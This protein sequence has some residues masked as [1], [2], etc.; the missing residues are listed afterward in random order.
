MKKKQKTAQTKPEPHQHNQSPP[1]PEPPHALSLIAPAVI[2]IGGIYLLLYVFLKTPNII[3][4]IALVLLLVPLVRVVGDRLNPAVA[5]PSSLAGY[6]QRY[7]AILFLLVLQLGLL[8]LIL[9]AIVLALG[10]LFGALLMLLS[11]VGMVFWASQHW[12]DIQLARDMSVDEGA[13]ML[14][15]FLFST[16]GVAV[17][18]GLLTLGMAVK[19]RLEERFWGV[20][21][22]TLK[23]LSGE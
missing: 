5:N 18:Y 21:H 9:P 12:F 15:M 1:Q 3:L 17:C 13:G 7:V 19:N 10:I 14:R 22:R 4:G 8:A 16:A 6:V 23:K 20:V 2:T 11:G